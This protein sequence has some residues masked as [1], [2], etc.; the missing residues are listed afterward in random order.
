M[1]SGALLALVAKNAED[2]ALQRYKKTD[3]LSGNDY[4]SVYTKLKYQLNKEKFNDY[5]YTF[6]INQ[7]CELLGNVDLYAISDNVSNITQIEIICGNEIFDVING[8]IKTIINTTGNFFQSKRK[9]KQDGSKIIIPLHMAPFNNNNLICTEIEEHPIKIIIHSKVELSLD[10]Y[11]ECYFFREPSIRAD[12]KY[13][14]YQ[15]IT[16]QHQIYNDINVIKPGIN[17]Y[18][19]YF[20][21]PIN[22]IYFWGFDKTKIKRIILRLAKLK[23]DIIYYDDGIESLEYYKESKGINVEPLMILFSNLEL[24]KSTINFSRLNNINND[25]PTLIIETEQEEETPFYLVGINAQV[26]E[27]CDKRIR[28]IFK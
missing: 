7:Q 20:N 28:L 9:I 5:K 11:A 26:Y 12:I 25:N 16:H 17:N 24:N 6:I 21:H 1:N 22:C 4:Q 27:T 8:D 18:K 19:L 14:Y 15:Y 13:N 23:D 3:F 10:L 2:E